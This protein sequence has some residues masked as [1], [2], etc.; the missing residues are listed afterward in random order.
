[1]LSLAANHCYAQEAADPDSQNVAEAVETAP[2]TVA[3]EGVVDDSKIAKRLQEIYEASGWFEDVEVTSKH[4]FIT[5]SGFADTDAHSNWAAE[6]ATRTTDVIGVSNNLNVDSKLNFSDS[7]V[8]VG[9]SLDKQ[10]REMLIRFPF[11][12]AGLSV[13]IFTWIVSKLVGFALGKLLDSRKVLRSSLKDLI[14]QLS[15]ITVWL[16]GILLATVVVFPGMTPA[17]A[18]TVLGLGSVAIGFA[19]KDIFENFFAGVLILWRYPIEKGD[20]L[21]CG[22]VMGKVEQITIRNTMLRRTDGELVVVPNAQIFKSNVEI[23]T[24]RPKRRVRITCGVAYGED[25]DQAREVIREAVTACASISGPKSV[26]IFAKEFGDSSINFEVAWWTGATPLEIRE[27]RDEVIASIKSALD[28]A[29][30]EIPF[31]YR[32]LTFADSLSLKGE[33]GPNGISTHSNKNGV[34]TSN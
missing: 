9:K 32:T 19:F 3:V 13:L 15:S 23:L 17:K 21:Q 33:S 16:L 6:I 34:A 26:E 18:L 24:S 10:Y 27:S 4:G 11:L 7:M 28:K 2:D 29:N 12:V 20:F 25:V 30:I 22:D 5:I 31:P 1:M 14:K 8:V